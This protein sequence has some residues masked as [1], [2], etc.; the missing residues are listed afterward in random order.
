MIRRIL[1]APAGAIALAGTAYA[2]DLTPPPPPVMLPPP[3]MWTGFYIGLNAGGTWSAS[4]NANI[5]SVPVLADPTGVVSGLAV[6]AN[7]NVRLSSASGFIGGGQIGYNYQLPSSWLAS[8]WL[9]S[10]WVVGIEA[11]ID[12]VAGAHGNGNVA[13]FGTVAAVPV[14]TNLSATKSLDYLGTVRGRFGFL[15]T[16]TLLIFGDGGLAYG[17]SKQMSTSSRLPSPMVLLAPA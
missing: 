7:G 1:L 8:S 6:L 5:A 9:A 4:N 11:D 15:W 17:G 14:T 10:G 2:A 13:T 12:G 16:P 3:P